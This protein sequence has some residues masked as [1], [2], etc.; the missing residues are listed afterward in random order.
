MVPKGR[1][2]PSSAS[3]KQRRRK[4]P[5]PCP[6]FHAM[7]RD[8]EQEAEGRTWRSPRSVLCSPSTQ[9]GALHRRANCAAS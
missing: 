1:G 4:D 3:F 5:P 9:H 6:K 7:Q 2:A 8:N